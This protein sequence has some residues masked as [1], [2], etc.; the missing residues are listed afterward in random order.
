MGSKSPSSTSQMK[1]LS[2]RGPPL[3]PNFP[4]DLWRDL[5]SEGGLER[6]REGGR[7]GW[8]EGGKVERSQE[9]RDWYQGRKQN[10]K[11]VKDVFCEAIITVLQNDSFHMPF[12]ARLTCDLCNSGV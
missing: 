11:R 6:G 12:I 9:K 5:R 4:S 8:R 7:E 3:M 10:S 1:R 2:L